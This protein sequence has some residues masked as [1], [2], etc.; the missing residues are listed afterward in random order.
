LVDL[1]LVDLAVPGLRVPLSLTVG[2]GRVRAVVIPAP[3]VA[4]ALADAVTGI[5]PP[6]SGRAVLVADPGHHDD[7]RARPIGLVPA[8]GGLLPHLTVLRNVVHARAIVD[9]VR[10]SRAERDFRARAADYGLDDVLDR[11]PYE[12]TVGRRRMVG[13]V[14]AL[15][16]GPGA[17][18][19]EDATGMPT[20]GAVLDRVWHGYGEGL[21]VPPGWA[22]PAHPLVGVATLLITC[23]AAGARPLDSQPLVPICDPEH[24]GSL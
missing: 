17:V 7:Q 6:G 23:S 15:Q 12:I 21:T 16:R 11:Y 1:Q 18:V 5:A 3:E 20:W 24:P 14:R 2:V 4:R 8:D 9:R 19:L 13:L 22:R 10:R